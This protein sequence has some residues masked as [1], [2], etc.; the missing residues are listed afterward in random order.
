M[1]PA[2][3]KDADG[4]NKVD[5]DRFEKALLAGVKDQRRC[6]SLRVPEAF[7]SFSSHPVRCPISTH[8]AC[9]T[10]IMKFIIVLRCLQVVER[11]CVAVL[12]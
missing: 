12:A 6:E 1:P 11:R 8:S 9:C 3:A 2:I 10:N 5:K 4:Y 7:V